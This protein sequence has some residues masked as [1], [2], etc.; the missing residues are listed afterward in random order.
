MLGEADLPRKPVKL[1][2][3][4]WRRHPYGAQPPLTAEGYLRV[5]IRD[6][7]NDLAVKVLACISNRAYSQEKAAQTPCFATNRT[8]FTSEPYP[9]SEISSEISN[10]ASRGYQEISHPTAI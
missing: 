8:E 3:R 10:F 2:F 4:M 9:C 6:E 5:A 1:Y 7:R